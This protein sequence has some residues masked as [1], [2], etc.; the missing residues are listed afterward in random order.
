MA[1]DPITSLSCMMPCT[2]WQGSLPEM[3]RSITPYERD[4]KPRNYQKTKA[5]E[6]F[7]GKDLMPLNGVTKAWFKALVKTVD[8]W[9]S[10]PQRTC[11]GQVA[12][13]ELF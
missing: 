13:P 8:Q 9:Y 10:M 7:T 5:I 2:T 4:S 1:K 3:F 11:W 12:L 6:E